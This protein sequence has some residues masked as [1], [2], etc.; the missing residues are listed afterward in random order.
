MSRLFSIKVSAEFDVSAEDKDEAIQKV[1]DFLQPTSQDLQ[2][3]DFC[4][5]VKVEECAEGTEEEA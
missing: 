3:P 4:K 1:K 5:E 2:I